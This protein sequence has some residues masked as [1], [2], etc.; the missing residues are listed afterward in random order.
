[1]AEE[2]K[3][4]GEEKKEESPAEAP[5][6]EAK[7]AEAKEDNIEEIKKKIANEVKL[8]VIKKLVDD[9]K[10]EKPAEAVEASVEA[11]KEEEKKEEHPAESEEK[12]AEEKDVF[13]KL[14][15]FLKDKHTLMLIGLFIFAIFIIFI[16]IK[17]MPSPV[18]KATD[19]LNEQ[20]AEETIDEESLEAEET[21]EEETDADEEEEDTILGKVLNKF[22]SIFSMDLPEDNQTEEE[23]EEE[24]NITAK[25]V[26]IKD[27][28]IS[29]LMY[30]AKMPE[31]GENGTEQSE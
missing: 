31:I 13:P 1:M 5:K 29:G 4:E 3:P 26:E 24:S 23:V 2:E 7:S 19:V 8:D 22:K 16:G 30:M 11:S 6:E 28:L 9:T 20:E 12:P 17:F 27:K 15:K 25:S 14:K 21:T 18:G 10:E